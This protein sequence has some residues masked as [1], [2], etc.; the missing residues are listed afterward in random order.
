MCLESPAIKGV[1]ILTNLI[2]F[3][4]KRKPASS[5]K[6]PNEWNTTG[7]NVGNC[8][9]NI[10]QCGDENVSGEMWLLGSYFGYLGEYASLLPVGSLNYLPFQIYTP[11]EFIGHNLLTAVMN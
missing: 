11:L 4:G 7:R 3:I 10:L 5:T 1:S 9:V 2:L 8:Q 6:P